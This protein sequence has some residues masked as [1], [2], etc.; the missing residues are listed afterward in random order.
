MNEFLNTTQTSFSFKG[1]KEKLQKQ[2]KMQGNFTIYSWMYC[3]NGKCLRR[4]IDIS[5]RNFDIN[6]G[7]Y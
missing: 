4:G 6:Q 7:R 1:L 5:S 3:G 2:W